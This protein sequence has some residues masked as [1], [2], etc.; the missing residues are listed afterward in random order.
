MPTDYNT[1][2]SYNKNA[3]RWSSLKN[4]T[5]RFAHTYIEKPA[6]YSQLPKD[7]N[8]LKVLCVGCGSGE[9]CEYLASHGA[10]VTGL[11]ISEELIKIATYTYPNIKFDIGDQEGLNFDDGSFDI[12]FSSLVIHYSDNW[13]KVLEEAKRVLSFKGK[14]VFSCHHPIRWGAKVS[15]DGKS[16]KFLMGYSKDISSQETGNNYSEV[17]GD[18]LTERAIDYKLIGTIDIK[19]YHK[20]ISE[21]INIIQDSGFQSFKFLEPKPVLECQSKYPQLYDIH[22][23]IP[24]FM[25][26]GLIK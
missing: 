10:I 5:N 21:I 8:G 26:F 6:M 17:I 13:S 3:L 18:Y 4:S 1:I 16:E 22:S 19:Y 11:D 24:M 25:V 9:E 12:V 14:Y 15:K 23:K 20:P 7:L 2:E